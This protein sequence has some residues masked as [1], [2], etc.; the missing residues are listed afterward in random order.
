MTGDSY[1][2]KLSTGGTVHTKCLVHATNAHVTHLLPEMRQKIA[3]V[4]ATMT[5][6]RPGTSLS[7][8]T[9]NGRR[10]FLFIAASNG[11][12]YLAQL[13]TEGH[14]LMFG[15]GIGHAGNEGASEIGIHSDDE[16]DNEIAGYLGG[17]L[18]IHFG[19]KNWGP[20]EEV[21]PTESG[22]WNKGRTKALW[23][24]V[25]G[26]SADGLPWVGKVPS[27]VTK[28]SGLSTQ[29]CLYSGEWMTA[30]FSG[31]GMTTAWMCGHALGK[32]ILANDSDLKLDW[33][34][35]QLRI[36]EKRWR[37]ARLADQFDEA[38]GH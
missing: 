14:E 20:E 16:Y 11:F 9:L 25:L 26:W 30:G 8:S 12:D 21:T 7:E 19:M 24:G 37:S 32:M 4:R 22:L 6:Q 35:D 13:P 33:M 34:P 38:W 2:L 1:S 29:N 23:T 10:S 28:R 27:R 3:P 5:A 18:P 15:G 17:A 31:E 36:S